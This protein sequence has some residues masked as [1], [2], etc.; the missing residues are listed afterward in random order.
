MNKQG[1]RRLIYDALIAE[2]FEDDALK[3]FDSFEGAMQKDENRRL[4]YDTLKGYG[5]ED[6]G[7]TYEE[8]NEKVGGQTTEAPQPAKSQPIGLPGNP[9]GLGTT[10]QPTTQVAQPT[11]QAT[12]PTPQP[13]VVEQAKAINQV[14]ASGQVTDT[15]TAPSAPKV[16]ATAPTATTSVEVSK[17]ESTAR[18]VS[19][20]QKA[21][22]TPYN[23]EE[24]QNIA[25]QQQVE[26]T[27]QVAE[28]PQVEPQEK[29]TATEQVEESAE[30]ESQE[31][32]MTI[33]DY[34][35]RYRNAFGNKP[36]EQGMYAENATKAKHSVQLDNAG[37][38][39]TISANN[40]YM[41]D[42]ERELEALVWNKATGGKE[43]TPEEAK[44]KEIEIAKL[45][46]DGLEQLLGEDGMQ[47]VDALK[48]KYQ[49]KE[50]LDYDALRNANAIANDKNLYKYV[51]QFVGDYDKNDFVAILT[52]VTDGTDALKDWV[53]N[54]L[55]FAT[56]AIS[57][58]LGGDYLYGGDFKQK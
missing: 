14:Q 2:G 11:T 13:Q 10:F 6:I 49:Q 37:D 19:A 44:A 26:S 24:L 9:Y 21:D 28:Q 58:D 34:A 39:F 57:Q 50:A 33:K 27:A 18:P 22:G 16:D 29:P 1:N 5:Y 25:S 7:A 8:F 12:Q 51:S 40:P 48:R 31:E 52:S 42:Y 41:A 35:E 20:V 30:D 32:G 43:L 47:Q 56:Y 45:S 53:A 4:I 46:K 15:P 55:D 3:D 54:P 38:T 23:A 36:T 17:V